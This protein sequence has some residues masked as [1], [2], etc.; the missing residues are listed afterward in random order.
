MPSE[1]E[2]LR[3]QE[4]VGSSGKDEVEGGGR[5]GAGGCWGVPGTSLPPGEL[6]HPGPLFPRLQRNTL[7]TT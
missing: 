3:L 6:P 4:A 5:G 7:W 2:C 1:D